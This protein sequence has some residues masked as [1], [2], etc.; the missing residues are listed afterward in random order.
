MGWRARS[1]SAQV[2]QDKTWLDADLVEPALLRYSEP[3]RGTIDATLW[4]WQRKARPIAL[5]SITQEENFPGDKFTCEF[6][7]LAS[8]PLSVSG[9]SGWRW[10][11]QKSAIE[12]KPVPAAPEIGDLPSLRMRRMKEVAHRFGATGEYGEE[13][14]TLDLRRMDRPVH[15]YADPDNNVIDAGIFVFASGTNPEALLLL[16]CRQDQNGA[17]AMH[18]GFARMSAGAIRA[19][20][21]GDVV[22]SCSAIADWDSTESYFSVF[23]DHA[24]V[25]GTDMPDAGE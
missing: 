8:E 24:S 20:L 2:E 4:V 13:G 15:R 10:S 21:D 9:K 19:R 18:F 7:S 17:A 3:T 25:F 6:V 23:G 16:E 12:W 22:W 11:P 1:L 5:V 14:R